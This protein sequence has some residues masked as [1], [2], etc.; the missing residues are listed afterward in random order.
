MSGESEQ[1]RASQKLAGIMA[2]P[3]VLF[4]VLTDSFVELIDLGTEYLYN[5]LIINNTTDVDI[6]IQFVNGLETVDNSEVIIPAQTV[7]TFDSFRYWDSV[8]IKYRTGAPTLGA[9]MLWC[10]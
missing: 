1:S 3:E 5:D 6:V 9:V 2:N 7:L 4:G 8:K 10:W